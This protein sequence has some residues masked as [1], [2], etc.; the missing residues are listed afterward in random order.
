MVS[1][2]LKDWDL[3]LANAE[4]AYNRSSSYTTGRSPF[5]VFMELILSHPLI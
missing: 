2:Y 5:E 3:K 1:K 4:F